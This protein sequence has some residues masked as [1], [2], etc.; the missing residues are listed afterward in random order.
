MAALG[1]AALCPAPFLLPSALLPS[2]LP[3][4]LPRPV[5]DHHVTDRRDQSAGLLKRFRPVDV[6]DGELFAE[7]AHL[8]FALR[9]HDRDLLVADR[10]D[11]LD[12]AGARAAADAI[13][14]IR[15]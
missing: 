2:A 6:F 4:R 10:R 13:E 12:A 15:H 11:C 5:L 14:Q 8:L 3:G 1:P 7:Q 9:Y